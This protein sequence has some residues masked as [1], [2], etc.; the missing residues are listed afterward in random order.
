VGPGPST[1]KK[2]KIAPNLR[3][4]VKSHLHKGMVDQ[5]SLKSSGR[6]RGGVMGLILGKMETAWRFAREKDAT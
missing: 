5:I 3:R 1:R 4:L 6:T 2:K